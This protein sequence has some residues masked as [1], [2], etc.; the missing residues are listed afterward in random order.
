MKTKKFTAGGDND[1][2]SGYLVLVKFR[3]C[4][5]GFFLLLLGSSCSMLPLKTKLIMS[6]AAFPKIMLLHTASSVHVLKLYLFFI[7]SFPPPPPCSKMACSHR[8][9]REKNNHEVKSIIIISGAI[10]WFSYFLLECST[11][12]SKMH[13]LLHPGQISLSYGIRGCR[14]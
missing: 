12:F 14:D 13:V 8:K 4:L 11:S 5:L 2:Y 6:R 7:F 3:I 1:A 10:C 9:G